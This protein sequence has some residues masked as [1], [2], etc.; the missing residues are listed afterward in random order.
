MEMNNLGKF[1]TKCS[2]REIADYLECFDAW[3]MSKSVRDD[4]FPAHFI[5]AIRLDAYTL[6]KT[7]SFPDKPI[8]LPYDK[9]RE[10]LINHFHITTFETRERAQLK[11]LVRAPNQKIRD[12]I[13]QLQIQASKCIFGDQL[14]TQ[15]SDRLIAGINIPK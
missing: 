3:R 9:L 5:T 6:V 10:L 13:L 15:L 4:K 14:H 8:S 11:K 12:F 1:P 7:L 2:P